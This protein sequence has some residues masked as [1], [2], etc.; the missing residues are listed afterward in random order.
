MLGPMPTHEEV[1]A[2]FRQLLRDANLP[3]PDDAARE[4][5]SVTFYWHGPKV[6]VIVDLDDPDPLSTAG[7]AA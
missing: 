4:P 6:A 1:E 7:L 3:E 5:G 2:R